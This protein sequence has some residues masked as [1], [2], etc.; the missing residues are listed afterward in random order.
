MKTYPLFWRELQ[1]GKKSFLSWGLPLI[2]LIWVSMMAFPTMSK[3]A[4]QTEALMKSLPAG[5]R[6]AFGLDKLSLG[7]AVGYFA[8]RVYTMFTLLGTLYAAIFGASLLAKEESERTSEFLLTKPISRGQIVLQK[9]AV[10]VFYMLAFGVMSVLLTF[11]CFGLYVDTPYSVE[12]ILLLLFAIFLLVYAFAGVGFAL[13]AFI[14][15]AKKATSLALGLSAGS[16][17]VGTLSASSESIQ[18]MK[19]IT[20]FKYADSIEIVLEGIQPLKFLFLFF[21]GTS[22]IALAWWHYQSK[23]IHA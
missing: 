13:S 17:L 7:E 2:F 18:W 12:K 5:I 8:T 14:P 4:E 22:G 23:D 16:F 20:L 6:A 3:S 11:A 19:W 15:K 9:A 10:L 1:A 21:V